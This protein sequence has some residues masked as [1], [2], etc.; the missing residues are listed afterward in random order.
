VE[1]ADLREIQ[2][3]LGCRLEGFPQT[4]LGLPLS[5]H[6]L[7]LADFAPLIAKVDKYLSGWC[8]ILLS[9]GGRVVLLNA[10]LDAIP[11]FSMAALE[12]PPALLRAIEAL[13]RAFL[14]NMTGTVSGAKCLMAWEAVC[15]PKQEG[16]LGLKCLAAKNECLQLKLVHRLWPCWAWSNAAGHAE[17]GLHWKHLTA[18][19]PL[20][21]SFSVATVGDRQCTSFWLDNWTGGGAIWDRWPVLL[22]H[23]LDMGASIHEVLTARVRRALVPRLTSA[24]ERLLPELLALVGPVQLSENVDV[25]S[26]VRCRKR[27]GALDTG[28]LYK[29]SS[30]G[31]V[32]APFYSFVWQNRAPSRVKFFA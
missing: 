20:Y 14:W 17:P 6:K 19:L 13:R 16:G 23:A 2:A 28:A 32:D 21:R 8:A 11:T 12:L 9:S 1:D 30:F 7:T 22:S 3:A 15:R 10:V 27:S 31:G 24:G 25:H 18:L 26:L 4:Y 29:L 5:C